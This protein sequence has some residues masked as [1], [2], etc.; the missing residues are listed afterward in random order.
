ML[1]PLLV[2]D[3]CLASG[4]NTRGLVPLLDTFLLA[5][6]C[7]VVRP[8][9]G[10]LYQYL[11]FVEVMMVRVGHRLNAAIISTDLSL[12]LCFVDP[13][14]ALVACCGERVIFSLSSRFP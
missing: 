2:I 12:V 6:M 11:A 14:S 10:P 8:W 13:I 3:A 5:C 4:R 1:L 7:A 9:L